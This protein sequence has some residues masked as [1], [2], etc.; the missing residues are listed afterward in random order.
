MTKNEQ[1]DMINSLVTAEAMIR[2]A[3]WLLR[4]MKENKALADQVEAFENDL[5]TL[6]A[7]IEFVLRTRRCDA[8]LAD[9]ANIEPVP[10]VSWE[11]N[12]WQRSPYTNCGPLENTPI[13]EVCRVVSERIH[14]GD[15]PGKQYVDMSA[16]MER[17]GFKKPDDDEK[18]MIILPGA[19]TP[20]GTP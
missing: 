10:Y 15:K 13:D 1:I 17:M 3:R 5:L 20:K 7:K 12:A 19:P 16:F 2:R 4:T 11:L 9:V 6:A 14:S 18:P 8:L